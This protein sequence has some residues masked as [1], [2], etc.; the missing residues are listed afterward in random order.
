MMQM[1]LSMTQTQTQGQ[2]GQT[3]SPRGGAGE[4]ME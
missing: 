2:R 1:N 4:G 3:G